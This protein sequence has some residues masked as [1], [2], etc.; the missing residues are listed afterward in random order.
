MDL[1]SILS[2]DGLSFSSL[3]WTF[4]KPTHTDQYVARWSTCQYISETSIKSL[5]M[6]K[7]KSNAEPPPVS[8]SVG[9]HR[10][11]DPWT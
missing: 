3:L 6:I 5:E 9:I 4:T 11:L 8:K 7:V 2:I 10:Q 1:K